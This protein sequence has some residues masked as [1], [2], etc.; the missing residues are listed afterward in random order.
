MSEVLSVFQ[1]VFNAMS[2]IVL[3]ITLIV[4]LIKAIKKK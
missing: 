1:V 4:I 3:L 2:F